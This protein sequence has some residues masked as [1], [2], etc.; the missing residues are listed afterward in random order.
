MF[1]CDECENRAEHKIDDKLSTSDG[2]QSKMC[3][4]AEAAQTDDCERKR[5]AK[6]KRGFSN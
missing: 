1:E 6:L 5:K 3:G 2:K 4:N